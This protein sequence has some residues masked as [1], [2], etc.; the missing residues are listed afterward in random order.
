MSQRI[1][2]R[3]DVVAPILLLLPSFPCMLSDPCKNSCFVL[4]PITLPLLFLV[5]VVSLKYEKTDS[6]EKVFVLYFI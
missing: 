5:V 4:H 3:S 6:T 2:P 1:S